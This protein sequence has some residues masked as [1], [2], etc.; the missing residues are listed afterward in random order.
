MK[1]LIAC[2]RSGILRNA[3]LRHGH[4]AYSAD[5]E[6]SDDETDRHFYGDVTPILQWEWDLVIAHPPCKY[7]SRAGSWYRIKHSQQAE[8][9]AAAKFF[10]ACM[11]ANA[12]YCAVE[13]PPMFRQWTELPGHT[14]GCHPYWFGDP[15]EKHTLW[16]CRN[17]PPLKPTNMLS[18]WEKGR[19]ENAAGKGDERARKRSQFHRGMADAIAQQWGNPEQPALI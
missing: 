14:F 19:T 13:N 9:K 16:W 11:Y 10:T 15:Y 2:E 1:V 18:T 5:I 8:V 12:L 17:L 6:R 3:F 7:L 4:D